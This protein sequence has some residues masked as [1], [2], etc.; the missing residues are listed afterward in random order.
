[1]GEPTAEDTTRLL[2]RLCRG[3]A[4]AAE[5]LTPLL[6]AELRR[7]AE[8]QLANGRGTPTLNPTALVHEAFL[9]L[10]RQDGVDLP[11][12]RHFFGLAS[13]VMRSVV[14]DHARE[15]RAAKRG[16]EAV[17]VT[18]D[19]AR[20]AQPAPDPLEVL[21]LDEAIDALGDVDAGLAELAELRLFGGLEMEAIAAGL[22]VSVRTVE[23]RWRVVTTWLRDRLR[24]A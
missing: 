1:M 18:V 6:V 7:L 20:V 17:R 4:R 2:N 5:E 24:D 16:G 23:R 10:V 22:D 13:K 9:R 11:S 8:A 3:D 15:R 21:S 19:L 14:V 12:R